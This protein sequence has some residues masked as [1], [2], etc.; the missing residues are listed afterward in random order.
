MLDALLGAPS[1]RSRW[2]GRRSF[3]GMGPALLAALALVGSGC[4]GADGPVAAPDSTAAP[5]ATVAPGSLA[6]RI[7]F[8]S[9]RDGNADVYLYDGASGETRHLT[10]HPGAD[11]PVA[12]IPGTPDLLVLSSTGEGDGQREALVR[13]DARADTLRPLRLAARTLRNPVMSGDGKAVVFEGDMASVRDLFRY[14]IAADRLDRLTDHRLG[15]FDPTLSPDGA[16]VAFAS[17]RDGDAEIY[18]MPIRG[19]GPGGRDAVRLTAFH[20]DDYA[21]RWSPT[22]EAIAFLS[23]REGAARLFLVAPDG[24]TLRR[25]L[26]P[27]DTLGAAMQEQAAVWSPDGR[28]IAIEIVPPDGGA[29]LWVAEAETGRR[30]RVASD[31]RSASGPA[32]S[33]A[34]DALVFAGIT[35]GTDSDLYVVPRDGGAPMRLTTSPGADWLPRWIGP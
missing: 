19:E 24:T 13:Y 6:G 33:P 29:Q 16:H 20:R 8:V 23:D 30:W 5:V 10:T 35:S 21:P 18:V 11:F 28:W 4:R 7:A 17:S 3:P 15:N 1:V 25:L 14:D 27:T 31:L 26:A 9:E 32:W 22:G 2:M 12:A 34:S